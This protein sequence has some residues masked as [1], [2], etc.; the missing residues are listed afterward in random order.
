VVLNRQQRLFYQ[1]HPIEFCIRHLN[2][3]PDQNQKPILRALARGED[4]S[5]RSGRGVGKTGLLAAAIIW[6][7][8]CFSYSKI[9]CTAPSRHQLRDNLWGEIHKWLRRSNIGKDF[10]WNNERVSIKGHSEE[11]WA[12]AQ[13]AKD[14]E[15]MLGYHSR[16]LMFTVD[17]ASGIEE[18][19]FDAIDGT[20][21]TPG[22]HILMA[23]NPTKTSGRFYDSHHNL[24]NLYTCFKIS[25]YDSSLVD[26]RLILTQLRKWGKESDMFR[27]HI[28]GEFPSGDPDTFIPL[29]KVEGA[30]N[31]DDVELDEEVHLGIDVAR[32]GSNLTVMC[33][34]CGMQVY[35]L[36]S[37]G[38]V[39]TQVSLGKIK[40][41]IRD[42]RREHDFPGK[43]KCYIDDVGVGA[44]IVDP[45]LHLD[46][47][48]CPWM[49]NIEVTGV[50]FGGAGDDYYANVGTR[51]W[52]RVRDL[53][54]EMSIPNDDDL[55]GQLSTRKQK[56]QPTGR[57]ILESK[58]E[59]KKRHEVSPDK[60]DALALSFCDFED[61]P[62]ITIW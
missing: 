2:M 59:M 29:E 34:R 53:L 45:L 22:S 32:K 30:V 48:D 6:K 1:K 15:G 57:T 52:A 24:R 62:E 9:P 18:P 3:T 21:S 54:D 19:I 38:R 43:I 50:N 23:G 44:A 25:G 46:T 51:A 40:K 33:F 27:C 12:K 36:Y 5:I 58:D 7:L 35:D 31:R 26:K 37:W 49:S 42:F 10:D 20:L 56:I 13:T 28:L 17:E 47:S 60:A 4:V 11:W 8:Y 41:Y 61:T 55:I 16:D 14:P 39:D